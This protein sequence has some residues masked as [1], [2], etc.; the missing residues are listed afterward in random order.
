MLIQLHLHSQ[1]Y[2]WL[3]WIGQKPLQDQTR[4]ISVLRFGVA[5]NRHLTVTSVSC[6]SILIGPSH[7]IFK[8]YAQQGYWPSWYV[9][10][11]LHALGLC[12]VVNDLVP[13]SLAPQWCSPCSAAHGVARVNRPAWNMATT[14]NYRKTSSISCTK[15]PNL[16]VSC[17]PLQLFL[18]NPFKPGVKLR[19]KM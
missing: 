15:S 9:V 19:M 2:I 12:G 6:R 5:Y 7:L 17:L 16:N 3:Q 1:C 13:W 4:N 11:M 10:R 8:Y 18:P 14:S